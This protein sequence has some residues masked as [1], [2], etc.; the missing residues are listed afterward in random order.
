MEQIDAILD[1][2]AYTRTRDIITI[3]AL[4]GLRLG[5][6]VKIRG[7]DFDGMMLNSLRKGALEHRLA[8]APVLAEMVARY[9]RTG[10]W[11]PSPYR[12]EKFP[13][14]G[15]HI[16]MESA[17]TAISKAIRRA[18]ITDR[19]LTG[20]SL[21]HFYGTYLARHGVPLTVIRELMAH[22]SLATTQ[23]YL[24]VSEDE[25]QEG[26]TVLPPIELRK[27]S[28]RRGRIAA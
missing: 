17:S 20:H 7:E 8:I 21:R 24:E 5:E 6:V 26:V 22:A 28:G 13:D 15:G 3:A 23:I 27:H 18:G 25:M 4:T 9:P 14:G 11:F 19:R 12:N 16:L 2:G 1:S 10:W